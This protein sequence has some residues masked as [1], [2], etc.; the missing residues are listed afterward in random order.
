M[1]KLD[2]SGFLNDLDK[3]PSTQRLLDNLGE[4]YILKNVL[5]PLMEDQTVSLHDL[6]FDAFDSD[7]IYIL[8]RRCEEADDRCS[9]H[10]LCKYAINTD[11]A[12]QSDCDFV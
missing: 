11:P 2:L 5:L 7:D 9:S 3:L 1:P 6:D 4:S 12:V 10:P 8:A